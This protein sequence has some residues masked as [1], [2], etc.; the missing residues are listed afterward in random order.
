MGFH[1]QPTEWQCGPFALTHALLTLGI[2]ADEDVVT[3][4]SGATEEGADERDLARAAA[5]FG[6]R[7]PWERA[8]SVVEARQRLATHLRAATP[9]LL[10]VDQWSHWVTA[11]GMDDDTVVLLD[12]RERSVFQTVPWPVLQARL[13]YRIRRERV[14]YDLHPVMSTR[15]VPRARFSIPRVEFLLSAEHRDLGRAW[16]T[17]LAALLPVSQMPG[18]QTEW[19]LAIGDALRE[20]AAALL[21]GLPTR[22]AL[23]SHR[24]LSHAAFVA[25]T[26]A[27][28]APADAVGEVTMVARRIADLAVAA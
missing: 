11:A 28:E 3:Q 2:V 23:R 22:G 14:C 21:S 7:M 12:S 19:T 18:A 13:A 25:D 24:H 9:V 4:V 20:H 6:C 8:Y 5:R 16:A 27:L 17:Y 26:H 15:P 1:T 10:C